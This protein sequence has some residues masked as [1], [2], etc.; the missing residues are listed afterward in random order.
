MHGHA[1]S[2]T[3]GGTA[4][5]SHRIALDHEVE[6]VR[7]AAQ[8]HVAHGSADHVDGLLA[9]ERGDGRRPAETFTYVHER[10]LGAWLTSYG[11]SSEPKRWYRRRIVI[12]LEA[13]AA[14]LIGAAAVFAITRPG[15][16]FNK[17][18]EF[19]AEPEQTSV[20]QAEVPKKKGKKQR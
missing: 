13:I 14:V 16:V 8:Q 18:V 6:L 1:A 10:H 11:M 7:R 15:D 4:R 20:P 9:L 3:L 5:H 17:D 12:V 19:R 2:K